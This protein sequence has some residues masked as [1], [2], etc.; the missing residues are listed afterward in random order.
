MHPRSNQIDN[1]SAYINNISLCKSDTFARYEPDCEVYAG[2]RTALGADDKLVAI[3]AH[4]EG[5]LQLLA[6]P[7]LASE[8]HQPRSRALKK[9][10]EI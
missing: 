3:V 2:L 10:F 4:D 8:T 5:V 1:Y 6:E 9:I 7:Q